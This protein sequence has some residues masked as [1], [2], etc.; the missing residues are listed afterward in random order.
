[1]ICWICKVSVANSKEHIIKKSDMTR[2]HGRGTYKGDN[3]VVHV[4][5]GKTSNIQGANSKIIKYQ[6]SLCDV[7]NNSKTQIFDMAYDKFIDYIYEN[8]ELIL[9]K[10]YIDF[11]DVY[12][13]DFE[14]ES[15]N[16]YKYYTK[17][18]GCCLIDGNRTVPNDIRELLFKTSFPTKLKI[19]FSVNEDTLLLPKNT[20]DGFI[21]K[22]GLEEW[23]DKK[24]NKKIN[25]YS[26]KEFVSWLLVSF[27]YDINPDSNEYSGSIWF[28]NN[29]YIDLGSF[30]SLTAEER[31]MLIKIRD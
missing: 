22:E 14:K 3:A 10:R 12:G 28:A 19:N 1:M 7:C 25:G 6:A 26:Y 16:L 30:R 27:W 2:A 21:G 23:L 31:K 4:K 17:S 15:I 8:E 5:N 20:R 13:S 11:F 9:E 18:F 24:D 29:Q